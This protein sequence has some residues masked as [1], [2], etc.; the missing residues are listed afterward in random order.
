VTSSALVEDVIGDIKVIDVDT[1]LTEP[2]DLW[3][4]RAPKGW[5]ERLPHV[6]VVDG[7]PR[8]ICDG[9]VIGNAG[10]A[11]VIRP[12]GEKVVG[13]EFLGF[14]IEDV[15][16]A[17]YDVDAR[18][19]MMDAMGV[20]AQILYPNVVGFGGQKFNDVIDPELRML[21]ATLFN[22]AMAEIQERS[23]QRLYPMAIV[24]WWDIEG[25]VREVE[26][27]HSL[28]LR[29]VNTNADPHNEGFPDLASLHW[30]PLW[31]VCAD[32]GLS[33]NFHIGGSSTSVAWFGTSPWPSLDAERKLAMGSTMIM[34]GNFRTLGNLLVSGIFERHPTLQVVSVESGLGWI[35]FLLE[36]LDW[37][38]AECAPHAVEHLS[39]S[40]SEYFRRQIHAC[41]WF[42][43]QGL[44]DTLAALGPDHIMFETDFPHPTCLYP[45]SL[46][47]AAEGLVDVEPSVREQVLSTNA[48]K[49]YRIPL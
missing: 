34:I 39:L 17:S 3:T 19:E 29:G 27:A 28:G 8:W 38:L 13:T 35:P 46:E 24:P 11:A 32:L 10:G 23:G 47:R 26:R 30:D 40:P 18:L 45:N 12:D 1:H 43:R 9:I 44:T 14:H 49:L 31:E 6:R 20:Y 33:V 42:E 5:E 2:H 15:H 37:E 36:V 4:A 16:P 41:Y 7:H 21:C 25:A 48:S 22:D